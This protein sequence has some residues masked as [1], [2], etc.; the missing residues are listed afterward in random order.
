[1][2]RNGAKAVR[3]QTAG[4][5]RQQELAFWQEQDRKLQGRIGRSTRKAVV[6]RK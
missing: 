4:M 5:T 1:M 3:E 6:K 2:K